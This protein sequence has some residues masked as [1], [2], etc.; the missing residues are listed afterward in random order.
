MSYN[1]KKFLDVNGLKHLISI[2]DD[3]P[4]NE[5]LGTVINAIES[6]IPTNVSQLQNDAGYLTTH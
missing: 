1:D 4:T 5:V 6:E 3:Y 2:L